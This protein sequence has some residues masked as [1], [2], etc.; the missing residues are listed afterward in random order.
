MAWI[1]FHQGLAQHHKTRR[2][3]RVLGIN[4]AQ[5]VGHMAMLWTWALDA[6]PDGDL[7]PFDSLDIAEQVGWEGDP[8]TFIDGIAAAGF[9]D[10]EGDRLLIH[11]WHNYGGKLADKRRTDAERKRLSRGCPTDVQRTS[12]DVHSPSV[13]RRGNSTV[14]D[15]TVPN[16]V[17]AHSDERALS[18]PFEEG[19]YPIAS[20]DVAPKG[21]A[22]KRA[23]PR[24]A[25]PGRFDEW[26]QVYPRHIARKDAEVA[27]ASLAP[28]DEL[29]NRIITATMAQAQTDAWTKD[30][31]E[32]VPYPATWLRAERWNDQLTKHGN[33]VVHIP[34]KP[35]SVREAF[36]AF[37]HP[38]LPRTDDAYKLVLFCDRCVAVD[39]VEVDRE[40]AARVLADKGLDE[41][42]WWAQQQV[43]E[44]QRKLAA[45]G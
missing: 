5:A 19:P 41:A 22:K 28:S 2:L 25:G 9:A 35:V 34:H 20:E 37:I 21:A 6:A 30:R 23:A 12:L 32:F 43:M 10:K 27:W 38:K 4:I 31:G 14:H 18:V 29:I 17:H 36:L 13:G 15:S 11:D 40:G 8:Q 3:K 26:W 45:S 24:R 42:L 44:T 1:E 33:N 7:S 39:K 16:H